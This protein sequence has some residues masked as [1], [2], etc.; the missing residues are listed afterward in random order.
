MQ[1]RSM[2]AQALEKKIDPATANGVTEVEARVVCRLGGQ[3]RDFRLVV[4]EEG[5]ILRG[6]ART[7]YAKQLAQHTVMDATGRLILAN[8]IEVY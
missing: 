7:Y 5:L 4:K 6:Q 8:E 1:G 3:I 2:E